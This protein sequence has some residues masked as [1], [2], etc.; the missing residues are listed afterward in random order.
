V[1]S[2]M[3]GVKIPLR[4][5]MHLNATVYLPEKQSEPAPAIFILTPYV[6]QTYHDR[7]VYFASHGYPFLT[8]DVR[9]R[10]NSDG[11][12]KA[13][14]N[15][16][17]DGYDIVEW[18]ARQP[19][20]NGQVTMWGGSYSGYVQ[21]CTAR[22]SPPHLATI[23]PVASPYRGV[24]SP[25]RNNIFTPY[26]IQWLTLL[27]GRTSQDKI[28]ADMRFWNQQF[29]RWFESGTAF[30][31]I[32]EF[33]G[34]SSQIFQQ[35]LSHP[36]QDAYWDSHNPTA[37]QYAK[38]SIPVLT[39]T[40]IYDG[41]QTG[42]LMHYR[43]HVRNATPEQRARHYLVIGPWDHAG[44]RTPQSRFVGLEVGPA[45]LVD[46]P[47]L[48][49]DWYAWV[50][51][52]GEKPAFLEKNV[53]YYVMG[54]E[55][56]RYADTLEAVTSEAVPYFFTSTTNPTDVFAA[57]ALT[58]AQCSGIDG[59]DRY[60]YDPRDLSLAGLEVTMDPE[61]RVDQRMIHAAAGKQLVYHSPPFRADTEIGG[62]FRLSVWLAIDQPDTDFRVVIQEIAMDGS[63]VELCKESMRARY[64]ESLRE[65]RLVTTHEPQCYE[66]DSF[67]FVARLVKKGCR[68]RL[69]IGPL[70]SIF[71]QK[72]FNTGGVVADET[73]TDAR[74]VT[75]SLF[76]GPSFP[77]VLYVPLGA[78]EA[79]HV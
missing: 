14:G 6:G 36:E 69:I 68:L 57:G 43:Q 79:D 76:H 54:A 64:R 22:E 15:E 8:V 46:L 62:F 27:A 73:M 28:F 26:R 53:A 61:S 47:K 30:R 2:M 58:P 51:Q 9:G 17:Q 23:V 72:N 66:L 13:N 34:N 10:G 59:T 19:Y 70:N 77:S 78:A 60:A 75:V 74:P 65:A 1:T 5:G 52:G 33:L 35:W 37:Q 48:H 41:N 18:L 45:A 38:L 3:W 49:R 29:R 24:D 11:V 16:A 42:A 40:G 20:C 56:W 39:I 63:A 31:R 44:T 32:D 12:F 7:G 55:R 25:M 21:W 50:M 67:M 4:D 71:S